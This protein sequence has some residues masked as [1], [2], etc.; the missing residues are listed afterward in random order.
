M[1]FPIESKRATT[2][3]TDRD[4]RIGRPSSDGQMSD[5][6]CIHLRVRK[7]YPKVNAP[8]HVR[9]DCSILP[10]MVI[11]LECRRL[12]R[13][14]GQAFRLYAQYGESTML[15]SPDKAEI[16]RLWLSRKEAADLLDHHHQACIIRKSL[17]SSP[18]DKEPRLKP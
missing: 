13:L 18:S 6:V 16:S 10:T 3:A 11:C 1:H 7:I 9:I 12:E 4:E 5:W 15:V 17:H 14:Y 8:V 2:V